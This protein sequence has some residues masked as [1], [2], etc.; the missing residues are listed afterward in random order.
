[1]NT[2]LLWAADPPAAGLRADA[3]LLTVDKQQWSAVA[4]RHIHQGTSLRGKMRAVNADL[5]TTPCFDWQP[6]LSDSTTASASSRSLL[7]AGYASGNVIFT[8][9]E[10]HSFHRAALGIH[11]HGAGAGAVVD[12]DDSDD[13]DDD[14]D[15]DE[16]DSDECDSDYDDSDDGGDSG[17]DYIDDAEGLLDA[18]VVQ[19][20]LRSLNAQQRPPNPRRRS[21]SSVVVNGLHRSNTR[22]SV[23]GGANGVSPEDERNAL[24]SKQAARCRI[25]HPRTLTS[26][27]MIGFSDIGLRSDGGFSEAASAAVSITASVAQTPMHAPTKSLMIPTSGQAHAIDHPHLTTI[28]YHHYHQVDRMRAPATYHV[29][30]PVWEKYHNPAQQHPVLSRACSVVKLCPASSAAAASRL[31]LSGYQGSGYRDSPGLCIWDVES[32]QR[33]SPMLD[34]TEYLTG[35]SSSG[36]NSAQQQISTVLQQMINST[37]HSHS[38]Q[39]L[40]KFAY[41]HGVV[42]AA[43]HPHAPQVPVIAAGLES[44]A[45]TLFDMRCGY[46]SLTSAD[47]VHSTNTDATTNVSF[48]PHHPTRL[49]STTS[50][51]DIIKL[52]DVR[53]F[54]KSVGEIRPPAGQ[55]FRHV[56]FIPTRQNSLSTLLAPNVSSSSSSSSA[57]SAGSH[58]RVW[59]L[60]QGGAL[61]QNDIHEDAKNCNAFA[62][63]YYEYLAKQV[64]PV[65]NTL[66]HENVTPVHGGISSTSSPN[67]PIPMPTPHQPPISRGLSNTSSLGSGSIDLK[68]KPGSTRTH[69]GQPLEMIGIYDPASAQSPPSVTITEPRQSSI[70]PRTYAATPQITGS[71]GSM[72]VSASGSGGGGSSSSA[73]T[74]VS[75]LLG[76]SGVSTP[77]RATHYTG[78]V[79]SLGQRASMKTLPGAD[80]LNLTHAS[81]SSAAQL[82]PLQ[83]QPQQLLRTAGSSGSVGLRARSQSRSHSHSQA[84]LQLQQLQHQHGSRIVPK[85]RV[86]TGVPDH[87]ASSSLHYPAESVIART[88]PLEIS[89]DSSVSVAP[90]DIIYTTRQPPVTS[91]SQSQLHPLV[92]VKEHRA[93]SS[94]EEATKWIHAAFGS[95][96][97]FVFMG[98]PDVSFAV[99]DR[100]W[101]YIDR[102]RDLRA[103]GWLT[104]YHSPADSSDDSA[105]RKRPDAD[106]STAGIRDILFSIPNNHISIIGKRLFVHPAGSTPQN[107][108][109]AHLSMRRRIAL[110]VCGLYDLIDRLITFDYSSVQPDEAELVVA[111]VLMFGPSDSENIAAKVLESSDSDAHKLLAIIL[112]GSGI[113]EMIHSLK[114][115]ITSNDIANNSIDSSQYSGSGNSDSTSLDAEIN[116]YVEVLESHSVSPYLACIFEF[117]ATKDSSKLLYSTVIPIAERIALALL[118]LSDSDLQDF[119]SSLASKALASGDL[120]SSIVFGPDAAD[121]DSLVRRNID[122]PTPRFITRSV[123]GAAN[124]YSGKRGGYSPAMSTLYVVPEFMALDSPMSPNM[125]RR[126][127]KK[128]NRYSQQ[129]LRKNVTWQASGRSQAGGSVKSSSSSPESDW[130]IVA[131]RQSIVSATAIQTNQ[132]NSDYDDALYEALSWRK[133]L[134]RTSYAGSD[135][136]SSLFA[137]CMFPLRRAKTELWTI[138]IA[139]AFR[140]LLNRWR[141]SFERTRFDTARNAIVRDYQQY[142]DGFQPVTFK[143]QSLTIRSKFRASQTHVL[144]TTCGPPQCSM[145]TLAF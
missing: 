37:H 19:T 30:P 122:G 109:L 113:G 18:M 92:Y 15:D 39:P 85:Q 87:R 36:H 114:L 104:V 100:L 23:Y 14:D 137:L 34:E 57:A 60:C 107:S 75:G 9:L 24:S 4:M 135:I 86:P 22:S 101:T 6:A 117:L 108:A 5:A 61:S 49:V 124:G 11:G 103:S 73:V 54:S 90:P 8:Q 131:P 141:L 120:G 79:P 72:A 21:S 74:A 93:K 138:H 127:T 50:S 16:T 115:P 20:R 56:S 88:L 27:D 98:P 29:L 13:N 64:D 76:S 40:R 126:R 25:S 31:L 123:D 55:Y 33:T 144:P 12:G 83:P 95:S 28:G 17:S 142:L 63:R 110:V 46:S 134:S 102:V 53:M 91:F 70:Q 38:V 71:A 67:Q 48:C 52:W 89:N 59:D 42:S 118:Y 26:S 105:T 119:I 1:M 32:I 94:A 58:V 96:S 106:Y 66:L 125:P 133:L 130:H 3:N 136:Q 129:Q 81:A 121:F 139:A 84:Q 143:T 2:R 111:R 44:N 97:E 132:P 140:D 41:G 78:T 68:L 51:G 145:M 43:W 77:L 128:E 62:A 7:V 112:Q 82:P 45:L 35:S 65:T 69:P 47:F 10:S 80:P 99:L 116:V